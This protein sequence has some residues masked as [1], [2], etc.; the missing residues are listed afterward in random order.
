M[1]ENEK[2]MDK[3]VLLMLSGGRDSYLAACRLIDKG[4][5]IKLITY[6]NGHMS[7][8]E[9][10]IPLVEKIIKVFGEERVSFAGIHM[11]AQNIMPF[12]KVVLYENGKKWSR[13]YPY[14]P[15]YQLICLACHTVMYAHSIAYCKA[16]DIHYIA[17]GAREQQKFFVELPEMQ[18]EYRELCQ[19]HGLELLL[20]VY[21][22]KS[23]IV[24]KEELAES[25]FLPKPC[26]PQCWLG[27]PMESELSQEQ[28]ECLLKYYKECMRP[29]LDALIEKLIQK[30]ISLGPQGSGFSDYL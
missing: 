11:I 23:D 3:T 22:L 26:E 10:V 25:G 8:T 27:C 18:K 29:H 19:A 2:K 24:R 12:L 17:E 30:K 1:E 16:Y 7:C 9:N 20:P 15:L 6:N 28:I 5:H 21:D 14:L 13:D 4:Y